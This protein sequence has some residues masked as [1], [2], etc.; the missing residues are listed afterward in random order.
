EDPLADGEAWSR[1][2]ARRRHRRVL[3]GAQRR[4]TIDLA[5]IALDAKAD[6][7]AVHELQRIGPD[8]EARR[9]VTADER[10]LARHDDETPFL[11]L[12]GAPSQIGERWRRLRKCGAERQ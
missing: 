3:D 11:R 10:A 5:R 4:A 7:V 12:G 6:P 1:I 8:L 9:A 2:H